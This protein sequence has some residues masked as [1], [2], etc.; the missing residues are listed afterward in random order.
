MAERQKLIETNCFDE[1][2]AFIAD[3]IVIEIDDI[4][5]AT[6]ALENGDISGRSIIVF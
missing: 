4:N 6:Q 3:N 5:E 1:L 2:V